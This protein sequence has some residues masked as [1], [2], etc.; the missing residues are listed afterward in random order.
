MPRRL[1]FLLVAFLAT[2][3]LPARAEL[4]LLQGGEVLKVKSYAMGAEQARLTLPSGG[5]LTVAVMRIDRILADEIVP[6]PEVPEAVEEAAAVLLDFPADAAAPQTPYGAEVLEAA[7]KFQLNPLVVAAVMRVES[8]YNHRAVSRAGA[9]GLM[10]LMPATAAR[11]GVAKHELFT[12][13]RNIEAGT[14][15]MRFLVDRL[16]CDAVRVFAAY[17]AGENA[18]ERYGGVPPYRETQDYVRKV[19]SALGVPASTFG[20]AAG[21][22]TAQASTR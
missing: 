7:R 20:S 1:G 6:P 12:P 15:Y 21:A 19:L 18:V 17:N 9:R 8:A 13:T 11:F 3:A 16:E 14:R 22:K 4:V 2:A 10:Q 5:V